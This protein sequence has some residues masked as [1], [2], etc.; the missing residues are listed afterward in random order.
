MA[1][2]DY[3][4]KKGFFLSV[5]EHGLCSK[6]NAFISVEVIQIGTVIQQSMDI[7][8]KTKNYKTKITR[9]DTIIQ[10][11]ESLLKYENLNI[12]TIKPA[13][14]EIIQDY[15][16]E[17]ENVIK[18]KF[19]EE[20]LKEL[21]KKKKLGE[22][23]SK[24]IDSEIES[25]YQWQKMLEKYEAMNEENDYNLKVEI[26]T[27]P[28]EQCCDYCKQFRDKIFTLDEIIKI[29]KRHWGCRCTLTTS[30]DDD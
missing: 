18:A 12:D 21:T 14:S 2:C 11:A 4:G 10:R 6:C 23:D 5:N 25:R 24:E 13:P 26:L 3:C 19:K 29:F 30:F 20:V 22:M 8:K 9:I 27:T 15:E 16:I 7:I 17:R 1:Q 28:D